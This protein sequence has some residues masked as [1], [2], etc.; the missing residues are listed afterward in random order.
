MTMQKLQ[1]FSWQYLSGLF[2]YDPATGIVT[3]KVKRSNRAAGEVVGTKDGKGYLH[4]SVQKK[5]I[6]LHTLGWF[7]YFGTIESIDHRNNVRTDNRIDNLRPANQQQ[8]SGNIGLP[9]HNSSGYKGV[10]RNGRSGKWHAQL[11]MNGKQTYL[12]RDDSPHVAALL[13]NAHAV[14][15]FG[16][17]ARFNILGGGCL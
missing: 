10:S 9:R 1:G 16:T 12:G 6:R 8:N 13:Y 14:E 17:F 11:K 2:D 4:V 5:F 3:R 7:L 15:H